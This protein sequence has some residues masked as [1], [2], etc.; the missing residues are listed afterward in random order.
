MEVLS[1]ASHLLER[2]GGHPMA[3][4]IGLKA[5][6]IAPFYEEMDREIRKQLTAADL[7]NYISYDGVAHLSELNSE[8]F[9]YLAM[10]SPFGHS[11]S[12]P[13]FR[14][15]EL[16]VSRCCTV[17]NAH[18]RGI[19]KGPNGQI[20]FIAFNRPASAFYGKVLDV[21]ATPQLNRHQGVETPQLN[22]IDIK[23]AY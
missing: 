3:V 15:N 21:L 13:V 11:N 12:K 10:L 19:L 16:Q 4:G 8:F 7:E 20:D 18:T 14:F 23:N 9:R 2:Y 5:E 6:N 1:S 17:G 22:I